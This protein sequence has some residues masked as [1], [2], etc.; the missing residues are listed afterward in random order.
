MDN[1][2]EC[3]IVYL[4]FY[5]GQCNDTVMNWGFPQGAVLQKE[6]N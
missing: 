1:T 2:K 5:S 3:N 6:L 4:G